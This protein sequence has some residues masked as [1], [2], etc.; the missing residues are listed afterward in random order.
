MQ[1]KQ[2]RLEKKTS[3]CHMVQSIGL[4]EPCGH[5]LHRG[6]GQS[7][8]T[9]P[10]TLI[11]LK[12]SICQ[13]LERYGT[14]LLLLRERERQKSNLTNPRLD[15][16]TGSELKNAP[17]TRNLSDK[18]LTCSKLIGA[19]IILAEKGICRKS[20]LHTG[21]SAKKNSS[22]KKKGFP[23]IRYSPYSFSLG[24]FTKTCSYWR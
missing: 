4:N 16:A 19:E 17:A 3:H 14:K 1:Q 20:E 11:A 13:Q 5:P 7:D 2:V 18:S 23:L 6:T 24:P 10:N 12:H 8:H 21:A 15:P 22:Y 9:W